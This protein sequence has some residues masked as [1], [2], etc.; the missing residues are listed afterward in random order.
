MTSKKIS[1]IALFTALTVA[2]ASIKVPAIIG[3]IAL[4]V[5]PALVIA[6]LIG[7][8]SG[9]MVACFGHL[10]SAL[11]GGMPLGPFHV[12]IAFEMAFL[13]WIFSKLFHNRNKILA[14][15]IFIIGNALIAPLPFMFF[16]GKPF[17]VSIVPSLL[18]GSFINIVIAFFL[19][20]RLQAFYVNVKQH[21]AER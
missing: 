19:A 10:I 1:L 11:F 13:V 12:M 14:G 15:F 2:G 21:E 3:S 9:A 18:I 4:D 5:F 6:I 7:S 16:I 8:S 17:Y 20:P